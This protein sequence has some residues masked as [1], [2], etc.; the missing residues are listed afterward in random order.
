MTSHS[1]PAIEHQRPLRVRK[2]PIYL[3][4]TTN[5]YALTS[6]QFEFVQ[7]GSGSG[8]ECEISGGIFGVSLEVVGLGR[9]KRKRMKDGRLVFIFVAL[10]ERDEIL[11]GTFGE[12]LVGSLVEAESILRSF[13]RLRET[14]PMM[15]V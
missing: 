14:W 7:A 2:T 6:D 4:V 5:H 12:K 8:V 15:V 11:D 13:V 10:K 9:S 1:A 3:C